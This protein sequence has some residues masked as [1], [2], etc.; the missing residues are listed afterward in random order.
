MNKKEIADMAR[1]LDHAAMSAMELENRALRSRLAAAERV[2]EAAKNA[3]C[4]SH[5]G[6]Y[7]EPD[8][9]ANKLLPP[10]INAYYASV[11]EAKG[12]A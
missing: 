4:D 2:V 6:Q 1:A 11:P 9:C 7:C 3:T 5:S 8:S 12:G 10:L